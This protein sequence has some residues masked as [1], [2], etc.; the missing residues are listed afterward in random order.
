MAA[1]TGSPTSWQLDP[2]GSSVT[3][4]H[5]HTWGLHTVQGRFTR[6]TGS[7]EI[8]ADGSGR[9]RLAID[10]SSLD[11]KNSQRDTHLRS[12]AFFNTDEHP[13]IIVDITTATRKGGAGAADAAEAAEATGSLTVA[14][15]TRPVTVRAQLVEATGEAVTLTAETDIS[16]ADFGMTWNF[17]GIVRG[18]AHVR[19]VARFVPA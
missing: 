13:Q 15:I 19:V 14:G 5:K 6:V 11:T 7:G 4:T 9:G 1:P 12:K 16:R 8:L 2:H 3:F 10:A 18:P 17:A